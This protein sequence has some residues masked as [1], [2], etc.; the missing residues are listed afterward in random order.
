MSTRLQKKK[1]KNTQQLRQNDTQL[2]SAISIYDEHLDSIYRQLARKTDKIDW[3]EQSF[4]NLPFTTISN[5]ESD[6]AWLL[7]ADNNRNKSVK[8]EQ[9][10][11][12]LLEM[13]LVDGDSFY[14]QT[15]SMNING[16]PLNKSSWRLHGGIKYRILLDAQYGEIRPDCAAFFIQY[17][18]EK[19]IGHKFQQIY[20][21]LNKIE[22]ES[23]PEARYFS[24]A[25][26]L[27][28]KGSLKIK[29]IKILSEEM[30]PLNAIRLENCETPEEIER[31]FELKAKALTKAF[32][33]RIHSLPD[34]PL[35]QKSNLEDLKDKLALALYEKQQLEKSLYYRLGKT[36]AD[37]KRNKLAGLLSLPQKLIKIRA[38]KRKGKFNPAPLNKGS[39]QQL[40]ESVGI[41]NE[42]RPEQ[43]ISWP[44]FEPRARLRNQHI[45]VVSISDKFTYECFRYEANFI[46]LTKKNWKAEIDAADPVLFFVESAW[47]GNDGE[48]TY[49]MASYK[50]H[51]G[52]PLREAIR[53][54]QS[55]KIP[56]VFWNKEDPTNYDVFIDVA[57]DCDYIFTTDGGIVDKYKARVGHDRVYPLAFAAQPAIHNPIRDKRKNLPV[58]EVC[59]AGSWYNNGHDTRRVQTEIVLNGAMHRELHIYDRMLHAEKHRE[60]R[61]FPA[62]YQPFIVGSL[63]YDQMVTAYRQYKLFLNI[64][65]VQDSP[66]MFSRRVFEILACGTPVVSTHSDGM[67][68]MLGEHV[69]IVNDK[70]E[71]KQVV[72]R[73]LESDLERERLG[74]L[75]ARHCLQHHS[76]QQRFEQILKTLGLP[77]SV[78]QGDKVSI[79]M[80]TNRPKNIDMMIDNYQRQA[81]INKELLIIL[82]NDDFDIDDVKAKVHGLANV[83]V[84]QLP[85]DMTLGDCLNHGVA[86]ASGDYIAKMDDDDIYG[87]NYLVDALLAFNYSG[88]DVVGKDSYFCYVESKNIMAIKQPGKDNR[89]SD[90][91]S[92]GTLVIRK[93]VFDK[94]KFHSR[95]RGED[96]NFL[97]DCKASGFTVY[98]SDKYNFIQMR[99]KNTSAHTWTIEDEE[100]LRT[101]KELSKGLNNHNAL[102]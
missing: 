40:L 5:V 31:I 53:Y 71:A 22:F 37:A 12:L 70:D 89:Y 48:W 92:G 78:D 72:Q 44:G 2:H 3:I 24:I 17:D 60:S 41:F 28:G 51:L 42:A 86:N 67:K 79:I 30:L 91:I 23:L 4:P 43:E 46:P 75:A 38:A 13:D 81:H 76:Y 80:C 39:K 25:L 33:K 55:K 69:H 68:A 62:Q 93:Q 100:Y 73:L 56:V 74:H 98:S 64:N 34:S 96:T 18:E 15:G 29:P 83:Q 47:N 54:C 102:I 8:C 59:F 97:K 9:G 36:L 95:N 35:V 90:F 1:A 20:N 84:H 10:G 58:Y 85:Q 32:E 61:I 88:A 26:R 11:E 52:D 66:T 45:N 14:L 65:T 101:C 94:V 7:P 49:T 63:S 99:Y 57:A 27:K 6:A 19:R 50:K 87:E 16:L 82:N 21:G 77:S